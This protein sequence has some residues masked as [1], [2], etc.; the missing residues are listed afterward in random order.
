M[1]EKEDGTAAGATGGEG[2]AEAAE[3]LLR[4]LKPEEGFDVVVG[5]TEGVLF[6]VEFSDIPLH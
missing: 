1:N 4:K 6:E 5:A 2:W 3:E